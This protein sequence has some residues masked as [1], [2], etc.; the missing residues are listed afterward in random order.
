LSSVVIRSVDREAVCQAADRWAAH[1]FGT[2]PDVEEIVVFGSFAN[3]TWAP[4]SDLDVLVVL[5]HADRPVRDR[6]SDLLPA[7]FPVPVDVFPYTRAE[8]DDREGS[9]I[10]VA[11]R[12]STWRYRRDKKSS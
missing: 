2:R 4:G 12:A 7:R 6:I 10:L 5:T 8:L 3:G 9:S 1:L 11:V